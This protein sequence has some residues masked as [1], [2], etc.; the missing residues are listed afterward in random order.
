MHQVEEEIAEVQR[1]ATDFAE[2]HSIEDVESAVQRGEAED[3]RGA[4]LKS[5]DAGRRLTAAHP[6]DDLGN[7]R[8]PLSPLFHQCH[9]LIAAIRWADEQRQAAN[10]E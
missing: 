8:L 1:F 10:P 4:A 3:W 7:D 6:E 9:G 5:I 2:I